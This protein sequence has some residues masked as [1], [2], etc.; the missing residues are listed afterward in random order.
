MGEF[1][2]DDEAANQT[3]VFDNAA[4]DSSPERLIGVIPEVL[5]QAACRSLD[6]VRDALAREISLVLM[7]RPNPPTDF[8]VASNYA[9]AI[10]K[11]ALRFVDTP[12]A[13]SPFKDKAIEFLVRRALNK[14]PNGDLDALCDCSPERYAVLQREWCQHVDIDAYLK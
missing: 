4:N 7:T 3:V 5:F 12:S 1:Q 9:T 11:L 6:N 10:V 8:S 13:P 14:F 2:S